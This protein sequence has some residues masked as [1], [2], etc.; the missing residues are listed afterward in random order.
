MLGPV[1]GKCIAHGHVGRMW[2]IDIFKGGI[3]SKHM[4]NWGN[5]DGC[6]G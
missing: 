5:L 3:S 2:K 6:V 4:P 1:N